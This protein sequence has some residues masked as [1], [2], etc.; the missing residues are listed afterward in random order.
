MRA[1]G[2]S[3]WSACRLA[4][5]CFDL[6]ARCGSAR[7]GAGV[8]RPQQERGHAFGLGGELQP[9]A[10]GQAQL[11]DLGE[12]AGETGAAQGFLERPKTRR[13]RSR[14]D[15]DQALRRETQLDEARAEQLVP[16]ADPDR[17]TA[18]RHQP[19][20]QHRGEAQRRPMMRRAA[21][22]VQTAARQPA[23]GQGAIDPGQP[24]RQNQAAAP[25]RWLH[26]GEPCAQPLEDNAS[27]GGRRCARGEAGLE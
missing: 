10:L 1:A 13:A 14:P 15:H 4:G 24:E 7:R 22:L 6:P 25:A 27:G 26:L 16:R 19:A 8:G 21:Q 11:L 2:R 3:P 17:V 5:R 9:P 18:R 23:A 20:E 12:R